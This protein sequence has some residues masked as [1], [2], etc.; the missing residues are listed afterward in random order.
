MTH[1]SDSASVARQGQFER[2]GARI[3]DAAR[4]DVVVGPAQCAIRAKADEGRHD[5]RRRIALYRAKIQPKHVLAL[6]TGDV[7]MN[8]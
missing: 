5:Q 2:Y 3:L 1:K 8:A 7:V 4:H 6:T